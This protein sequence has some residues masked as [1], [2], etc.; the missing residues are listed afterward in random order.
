MN[1]ATGRGAMCTIRLNGWVGKSS[2][3]LGKPQRMVLLIKGSTSDEAGA[4]DAMCEM[5]VSVINA[6][7]RLVLG[8]CNG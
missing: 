4:F 2:A 1:V 6:S 5:V 8:L 7:G 3:G